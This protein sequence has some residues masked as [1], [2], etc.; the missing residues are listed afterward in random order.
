MAS[1]TPLARGLKGQ[2]PNCGS[3]GVHDGL[4]ELQDAC[5]SC[6]HT[7]LREDGYWVGAMTV[8][9]ALIIFF[10][11]LAFA[12]GVLLTWP[13][14]PW[15]TVAYATIGV[16]ALVSLLAYGWAKTIWVGLDL[17][18]NPVKAEGHDA[19]D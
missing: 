9:M 5:P 17:A 12:V 6:R 15:T 11:F 14:V 3:R 18:F 19:R 16:N 10:F 8:L 2:C 4:W 7:F 13:D 1:F